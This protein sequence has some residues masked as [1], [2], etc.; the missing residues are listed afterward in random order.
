MSSSKNRRLIYLSTFKN[1]YRAIKIIIIFP[2]SNDSSLA[3]IKHS[4]LIMTFG[5]SF[6]RDNELWFD[7]EEVQIPEVDRV[8]RAELHVQLSR[9]GRASLYDFDPR[10]DDEVLWRLV[11]SVQAD[12]WGRLNATGIVKRWIRGTRK[13]LQGLKI[14][15]EDGEFEEAFVAAYFAR[16]NKFVSETTSK[17][18]SI[19]F[20][21]FFLFQIS[22]AKH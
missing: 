22:V 15:S 17:S 9:G 7:H 14:E 10:D 1:L 3:M 5:E 16:S 11:D 13:S 19:F 18:I 6:R 2:E 20:L 8:I 21:F 4:D 12:P